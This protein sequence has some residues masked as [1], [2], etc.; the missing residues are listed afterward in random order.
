MNTKV[1][2]K[3]KDKF[4]IYIGRP[5]K[6]GNPFIIGKDGTREEAIEKYKQYFYERIKTD[7]EFKQE[8]L[9]L[10][11]KTLGC[12]CKPATCHGDIIVSWLED[13]KCQMS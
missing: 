10:E 3:R 5:S 8:V 6:F 4:D 13:I 1:V 11:G 12:F 9:K 7:S 2:N